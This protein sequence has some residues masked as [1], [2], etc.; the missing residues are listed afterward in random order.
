MAS[1]VYVSSAFSRTTGPGAVSRAP[2]EVVLESST[3][4]HAQ[5]VEKRTLREVEE[6]SNELRHLVGGSYRS[7]INSA[8]TVVSMARVSNS[9]V[10]SVNLL[11]AHVEVL[12]RLQAAENPGHGLHGDPRDVVERLLPQIA[13][14]VADCS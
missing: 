3:V 11:K 4:A 14:L 9:V 2:A 8:D 13:W 5:E 1:T 10:D 6:K 12:Q 7:L